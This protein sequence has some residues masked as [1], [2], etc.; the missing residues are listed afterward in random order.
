MGVI[1]YIY[2][3]IY[4]Q[5]QNGAFQ[6]RFLD[7]HGINSIFS[8]KNQ[9]HLNLSLALTS[10]LMQFSPSPELSSSPNAAMPCLSSCRHSPITA[11]QQYASWVGQVFHICVHVGQVFVFVLVL[12]DIGQVFV[13]VLDTGQVFVFVF[14]LFSFVF[15]FICFICFLFGKA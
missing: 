15:L 11:K 14:S 9:N 5:K 12:L 8:L 10:R 6:A 2:I 4:T 3:Y 7:S 13:F 1:K